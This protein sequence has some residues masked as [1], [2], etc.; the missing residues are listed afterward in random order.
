[1]DDVSSVVKKVLAGFSILPAFIIMFFSA[2]TYDKNYVYYI[3]AYGKTHSRTTN[4]GV[5]SLYEF[6]FGSDYAGYM[7]LDH[8][9]FNFALFIGF[10]GLIVYLVLSLISMFKTK[11]RVWKVNLAR[12][13]S[14]G[15]TTFFLNPVFFSLACEKFYNNSNFRSDYHNFSISSAFIVLFVYLLLHFVL[16]LIFFIKSVKARAQ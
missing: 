14:C 7:N 16:N 9:D 13:I 12:T 2:C 15:I 8:I 10:L 11:E 1:M 5:G 3:D 6:I 4:T